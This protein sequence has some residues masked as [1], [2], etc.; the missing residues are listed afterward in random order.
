MS[1]RY[2]LVSSLID[3]DPRILDGLQEKRIPDGRPNHQVYR[4][5][6]KLLQGLQ[7]AK[8]GVR[9]GIESR[10]LKLDHK[11]QVTFLRMV[12]AGC[13][14]A[15]QVKPLDAVTEADRLQFIGMLCD[16]RN[17]RTPS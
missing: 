6:E 16:G 14:R 2:Y 12:L 11:V 10:R 7:Q 8:V 13:S 3:R 9:I 17:H 5:S 4:F 15:E 1:Y